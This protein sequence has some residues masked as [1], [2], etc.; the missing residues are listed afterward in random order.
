[1]R[2]AVSGEVG[3]DGHG[4]RRPETKEE[5]EPSLCELRSFTTVHLVIDG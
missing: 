5:A 3:R 4:G 2:T 1:V